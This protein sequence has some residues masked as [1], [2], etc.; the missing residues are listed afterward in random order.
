MARSPLRWAA[1]WKAP[2]HASA[3]RAVRCSV[4]PRQP[5]PTARRVFALYCTTLGGLGLA[6][7]FS[8]RELSE[9]TA[10]AFATLAVV[11]LVA[12][13]GFSSDTSSTEQVARSA[14]SHTGRYLAPM[15][16]PRRV[17]AE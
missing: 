14:D 6:A 17:A 16:K 1:R 13:N 2:K 11:A 12:V 10:A 15:L 5:A 9:L 3:Y 4:R 7:R 8:W